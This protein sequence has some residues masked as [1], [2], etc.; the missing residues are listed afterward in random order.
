MFCKVNIVLAEYMYN[1]QSCLYVLFK[2][3]SPISLPKICPVKVSIVPVRSFSEQLFLR[4]TISVRAHRQG[5]FCGSAM[6]A[7]ALGLL[8]S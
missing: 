8:N 5:R 1:A 2:L 4:H 3:V 7:T 6:V